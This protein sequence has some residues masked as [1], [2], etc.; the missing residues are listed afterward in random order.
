MEESHFQRIVYQEIGAVL[1]ALGEPHRIELLE[2]LCHQY[3][4]H[5]NKRSMRR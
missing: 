4:E 1:S 5:V 3:E 2:L